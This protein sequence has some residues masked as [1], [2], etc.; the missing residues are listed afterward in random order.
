M[1]AS[2]AVSAVSSLRG[3]AALTTVKKTW[4]VPGE[5]VTVKG[6]ETRPLHPGQ[7]SFQD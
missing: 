2:A 7:E 6:K 5:L 3:P 1:S 4:G